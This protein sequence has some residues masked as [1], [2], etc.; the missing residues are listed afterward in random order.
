VS[1]ALL[2]ALA[3]VLLAVPAAVAYRNPTAGRDLVL[4]IPGMH[5]AKVRRKPPRRSS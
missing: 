1:K 2:V 3:V 4:Q 5:R